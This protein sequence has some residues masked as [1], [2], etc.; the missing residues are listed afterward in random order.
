MKTL[1][2]Q[3]KEAG[4]AIG[5]Q[6]ENIVLEF[7]GEGQPDAVVVEPLLTEVKAR[8]AE[9]TRYL[10]DGHS[11]T[12]ADIIEQAIGR[13]HAW[14]DLGVICDDIDA[15]YRAGDIDQS[16]AD[17]LTI[18]VRQR[19]R[20]VPE[21]DAALLEMP[22][23]QFAQSG[24]CREV[25]STVLGES[26]LMAADNAEVPADTPLVVYRAAELQ[27]LL[28]ATPEKLQAVHQ[29]KKAFDGEV[30]KE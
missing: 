8:K 13:A 12:T 20:E 26:F 30:M 25:K 3:L 23:S 18:L 22:L 11:H 28:G 15:A 19:S 16:A 4:Y 2:S 21:N 9:M 1:L 6:G 27:L 5:L 10:S 29:L 24:I 17:E 14:A 7:V